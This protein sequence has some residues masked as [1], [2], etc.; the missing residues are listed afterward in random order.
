MSDEQSGKPGDRPGKLRGKWIT[1]RTFS[2]AEA[3]HLVKLRLDRAGIPSYIDN[4]NTGTSLWIVQPAV[5]GI[6]LRVPAPF[7]QQ[8]KE[9]LESGGRPDDEDA[10]EDEDDEDEEVG[11]DEFAEETDEDRAAE[12]E[13]TRE[14]SGQSCP[15]CHSGDIAR[16]SWIRRIGQALMVLSLSALWIFHP[17][18]LPLTVGAA[19]YLLITKP[20][21]RCLRCGKRWIAQ[22]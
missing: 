4:E 1:V 19:I 11:L 12:E 3:A 7:E 13:S 16:F 14:M 18:L 9:V 10:R 21:Y 6:K 17:L 15:A 8:A 5:G 22:R 2:T 20:D